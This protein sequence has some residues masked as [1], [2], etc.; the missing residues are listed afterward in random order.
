LIDHDY[1]FFLFSMYKVGGDTLTLLCHGSSKGKSTTYI[2]GLSHERSLRLVCSEGDFLVEESHAKV[3]VV[4][5]TCN[6][7]QEPVITR[8]QEQCSPVGADG[9]TDGEDSGVCL[10]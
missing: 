8:Q 5:A 6:R 1:T 10:L 9:R 7:R 4:A 3:D 2:E